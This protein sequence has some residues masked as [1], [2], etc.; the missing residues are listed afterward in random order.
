M[1]DYDR[2][3]Y[4]WKHDQSKA[5]DFEPG[6]DRNDYDENGYKKGS[7]VYEGDLIL[8]PYL[9]ETYGIEYARQNPLNR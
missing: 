8:D 3:Y 9:I 5:R 4:N 7:V 2:D 1:T 6:P